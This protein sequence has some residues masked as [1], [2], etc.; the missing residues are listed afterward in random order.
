MDIEKLEPLYL[1]QQFDGGVCRVEIDLKQWVDIYPEIEHY[2]LFATSPGGITYPVVTEKTGNILRWDITKSDTA[3]VGKGKYQLF[4]FKDKDIAKYSNPQ[5]LE[6]FENMPGLD[7]VTDVP[8]YAKAWVE[9]VV[10][11]AQMV[12][13]AV[14][15]V[16]GTSPY[17][18]SNGNWY[19]YFK[20]VN[21]Y[22]DT[23]VSAIGVKGNDGRGI[24]SIELLTGTGGVPGTTDIYEIIYTDNTSS[25]FS[26]YNGANGANGSSV[27]VVSVAQ[28]PMDGGENEVLF[29]DGKKLIVKNGRTGEK[30]D[31]GKSAYEI[32]LENGFEGTEEEWLESLKQPQGGGITEETDPTVPDWAKQPNKPAY[33]A[34]EVGAL[35][36]STKI[37]SKTSDLTN[38]SGFITKVAS[39]LANYYAKSESYTREEIDQKISAIPKFSIAVVDSLP[40]YGVSD[41]TVYLLKS[42]EGSDLYTEFINVDGTWEILGSQRVN[43]TGY[44]TETWTL[45]KLAEYQPK[46]DYALKSEVPTELSQLS[47]DA[48][49][50]TVT[51]AEKTAWNAKS[52]FSGDY[53]DLTGKP[54]IP[55]VPTNVSAF[56]NDAGYLVEKDIEKK[57]DKTELPNA[58]NQALA[59]AKESGEFDGEKGDK[60]DKGEAGRTPV[61]GEDYFTPEDIA[62][63][64]QELLETLPDASEVRY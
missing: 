3:V 17:I 48:S 51:D 25:R 8:D 35:P 9:E 53:K 46:G 13:E 63:I 58:I 19:I 20:S 40:S 24:V 39:D 22:V 41:T 42:G 31:D 16:A 14:E 50:R 52:N 10:K 12:F 2:E 56:N 26:V 49:N 60:G 15:Q 47:G 28:S 30:G 44:A 45:G 18:G 38:D 36:A 54:T 11:E 62:N 6:V 23:G 5:Q 29:S 32:A 4:G 7:N 59:Q 34:D 21:G 1:G 33:T 57:L 61:K 27:R 37:P 64:V 43:L 55:T